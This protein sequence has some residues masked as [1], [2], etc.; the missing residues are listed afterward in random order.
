M[1]LS[2]AA[3]EVTARNA[4]F[5]AGVYSDRLARLG[6]GAVDP[7]IVPFRGDYYVLRPQA[8][9]LANA[10]VYPVPDPS[11]PFL[12]IHTTLRM[13]GSMWL[14]PN[15]VLALGRESYGRYQVRPRDL[16]ETVR[17]PGFR[18]LA[19]KHLRTGTRG[20]G[21]RLRASICSSRRPGS[22]CRSSRS[23]TSRP[24]TAGIRAQALLPTE[25]SWT[26]SCWSGGRGIVHVRNAPSPGA[27]SSLHDRRDDRGHGRGGV[28]ALSPPVEAVTR[29]RATQAFD[30]RDA[31]RER[32]MAVEEHVRPGR[33]VGVCRATSCAKPTNRP[34]AAAGITRR[35]ERLPVGLGLHPPADPALGRRER[36]LDHGDDEQR[37][38]HRRGLAHAA[39]P[40]RRPH[41]HPRAGKRE[42]REPGERLRDVVARVVADLVREDDAHLGVGEACRRPSCSRGRSCGRRRSRPR[43]RSPGS[44]CR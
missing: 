40:P 5:C 26:T 16:V 31:L 23:A 33:R 3:G 6:G 29:C 25:A 17:A 37:E 30:H 43:R 32:R 15:A 12:G 39:A 42:E 36:E 22:C 19:R 35:L 13:D 20:D 27:T 28:R 41:Q 18:R 14:G 11:F 1:R 2:C 7:R 8:R 24:A 10:L 4:V 44:S 34:R 38:R 21:S 9:H